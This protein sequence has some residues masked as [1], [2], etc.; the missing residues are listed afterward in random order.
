MGGNAQLLLPVVAAM[1]RLCLLLWSCIVIGA[2]SSTSTS[3]NSAV[4]PSVSFLDLPGRSL[5][6]QEK[7]IGLVF[8]KVS[9]GGTTLPAI[10]LTN[11]T[12]AEDSIIVTSTTTPPIAHSVTTATT[13][14]STTAIP[15]TPQSF[16]P[17][18]VQLE[19]IEYISR[20]RFKPPL[21]PE[22]TNP[23]ADKPILRGSQSENS[24]SGSGRNRRP[25]APPP[26]LP[27]PPPEQERIPI[28]PPDLIIPHDRNKKP[29]NTPARGTVRP[30]QTITYAQDASIRAEP[31]NDT[32]FDFVP[33]LQN[34]IV[35]RILS[36]SSG[37]KVD[38][39]G[40]ILSTRIHLDHINR[41]LIIA[42]PQPVALSSLHPEPPPQEDIAIDEVDI[43]KED[44]E[45]PEQV[46]VEVE[47]PPQEFSTESE[48][49]EE[50]DIGDFQDPNFPHK[51]ESDWDSH[52]WGVAW[53]IHIYL[54]GSLF[55]FLTIISIVN[56]I[57]TY[58]RLLTKFYFI[59]LNAL[60][61]IIGIFRS[62]FLFFDAYN[63]HLSYPAIIAPLM[64]NF[65]FPCLTTAFSILFLFL[66]QATK[67]KLNVNQFL[68]TPLVVIIVSVSHLLLCLSL[69]IVAG[70]LNAPHSKFV[71]LVCQGLFLIWGTTLSVTYLFIFGSLSKAALRQQCDFLRDPFSKLSTF[72]SQNSSLC[73]AVRALLAT[74]M[75]MLLLAAVQLYGIFGVYA[76]SSDEPPRPWPWWG[77]QFSVRVI[78]VS[79]CFLMV[80]V[81]TLRHSEGNT[82][83]S[84]LSL[85]SCIN[86]APKEV[87]KPAEDLYPAICSTNQTIHNIN[88]Q[89][90]GKKVY[91]SF[92]LSDMPI[93]DPITPAAI[94]T[95]LKK[96]RPIVQQSP[97]EERRSPSSDH[98]KR[99]SSML[100]AE[101]GFVRFRTSADPEQPM[102]EVLHQSMNRKS[103]PHEAR[104]SFNLPP[105]E[106]E[107]AKV[108]YRRGMLEELKYDLS[109]LHSLPMHQQQLQRLHFI[110]QGECRGGGRPKDTANPHELWRNVA[111]AMTL[112]PDAAVTS[113]SFH[114]HLSPT[115]LHHSTIQ[116]SESTD[117]DL[118]SNSEEDHDSPH[119]SS[120]QDI[121]PDSAV[122]SDIYS[123]NGECPV[124]NNRYWCEDE[125]NFGLDLLSRSL[126]NRLRG[127]NFSINH[128]QGYTPL[129]NVYNANNQFVRVLINNDAEYFPN[130]CK[131]DSMF[132]HQ[133]EDE[134]VV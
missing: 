54:M 70:V 12:D 112:V 90:A 9:Y 18:T 131:I 116:P 28:R 100:F 64:L 87:P 101:D 114:N 125:Q 44:T 16:T 58:K 41:D 73:L 120:S 81:A 11:K 83:L 34:P 130:V 97:A 49:D 61:L 99:P 77:F 39:D 76:I 27:R 42:T 46:H 104:T 110:H 80:F 71:L 59:S 86:R 98:S 128:L 75:L 85:F 15:S 82:S 3:P 74:A 126:I 31:R 55:T 10:V 6:P 63:L 20:T 88:L 124:E 111:A 25:I 47:E 57:R 36:G 19:T 65:A 79:M 33:I 45:E 95:S 23:F 24:A 134:S 21:P 117:S 62:I 60:L 38:D 105:E 43:I 14:T 106:F 119:P 129:N 50:E 29:L 4:V 26:R 122:G 68:Q 8:S 133:V 96:S 52:V 115:H 91:D 113:S 40:R 22:Y 132:T 1:L 121:T 109:S 93:G 35:T 37:R 48:L 13:T 32:E 103:G 78:E 72:P 7:D 118:A 56:F 53:D 84:V 107:K 2:H 108:R 5:N 66:L 127:S 123:K 89:A 51:Q 92:P 17:S 69:D 94:R 30:P 102:E 67:V